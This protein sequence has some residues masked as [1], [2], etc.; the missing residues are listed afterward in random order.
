MPE[1]KDEQVELGM[2]TV[3]VIGTP[4]PCDNEVVTYIVDVVTTVVV[5]NVATF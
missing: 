5:V 4:T 3:E 2:R 1:V